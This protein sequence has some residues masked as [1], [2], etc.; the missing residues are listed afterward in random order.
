MVQISPVKFT[1]TS[2]S[3]LSGDF[4]Q[5]MLGLEN[6]DFIGA[7]GQSGNELLFTV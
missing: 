3:Y 1:L 5:M 2:S 7:E 6:Q 4:C